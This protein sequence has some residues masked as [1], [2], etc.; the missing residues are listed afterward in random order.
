ME[1]G[2]DDAKQTVVGA[3]AQ[4]DGVQ[5]DSVPVA[6]SMSRPD[7]Y[8]SVFGQGSMVE[9]EEKMRIPLETGV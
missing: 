9:H 3:T 5:E 7:P 6:A 4:C 8:K 2:E 1:K